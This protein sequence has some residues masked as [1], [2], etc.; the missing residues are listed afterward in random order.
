MSASQA[1]NGSKRL[2][3]L[4]PS[5]LMRHIEKRVG[6]I[7]LYANPSD[8]LRDLVRR[9]AQT[10][11]SLEQHLDEVWKILMPGAMADENEFTPYP[12]E[13]ILDRNGLKDAS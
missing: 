4:M 2:Q 5:S 10:K 12:L 1:K 6:S 7:G 3:V 13:E 9:D 11:L 8:Y